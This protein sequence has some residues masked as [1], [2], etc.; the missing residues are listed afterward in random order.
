MGKENR[1]RPSE[2][3]SEANLDPEQQ[4]RNATARGF[5]NRQEE[6]GRGREVDPV[7]RDPDDRR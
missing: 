6:Q 1:R 3:P 7:E 5:W 4:R 2:S